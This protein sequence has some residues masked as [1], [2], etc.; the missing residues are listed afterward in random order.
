[1]KQFLLI[2]DRLRAHPGFMRYSMNTGWMFAEKALRLVAGL[3]VG[4]YMARYLGKSQYGLLN[5]AYSLTAITAVVATWGMETVVIRALVRGDQKKDVLLGTAFILRV[6]GAICAFIS[7]VV[8]NEVIG[9]DAQTKTL[10]YIIGCVSFA[11]IF[12]VID[13]YFQSQVSSKYVVWS[14]MMALTC[15]SIFRLVLIYNEA[16]LYWFAVTYLTDF[17]VISLGLIYFYASNRLSLFSWKWDTATAK[18]ILRDSWP[19]IFSALA[20]T[21]YLRIDQIMIKWMMGD[22]ANGVY[23]AAVRLAEL[24]NFIPVAICNS[25]FPAILNA[26]LT[27]AELYQKRVSMLFDFMIWVSI[28]I[29]IPAALLSDWMVQLLFGADFAQAGGVL[30]LYIWSSVFVFLGVANGKWIVSENLQVFRMKSL[31]TSCV[32]NIV[33]N[34]ILIPSMGLY[35]SAIATIVSY[36]FAGYF[37]FLFS[38]RTRPMFVTMSRSFNPLAVWRKLRAAQS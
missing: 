30:A 2:F 13:Y 15:T 16:D 8:F 32:L 31:L 20:V 23:S 12:G 33:L 22:S 19:M 28:G 24:W 35:G 38:A 36:A 3:F 4:A 5:Y 17:V 27:D 10:V 26:K 1:L 34:L 18:A 11:E 9:S 29:S 37:S 6:L 7:L 25:V 14:Q 21:I